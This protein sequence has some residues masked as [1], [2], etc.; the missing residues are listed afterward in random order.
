[1]GFKITISEN[2]EYI[3]GKIYD[4]LN[5]ETAQQLTEEYVKIIKSTGIKKILNDVRGTPDAMGVFNNYEFAYT[6]TKALNFP[7][8]IHAAIVTDP[9]DKTHDFPETVANNAG[10]SV[11]VFK[12][13]GT[14]VTWL[15]E[16]KR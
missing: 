5:K 8:D 3:I 7:K 4:P 14:A 6:V 13:I 11:K 9:N 16:L 10:Y 1:M 12:E 15:L 2:G